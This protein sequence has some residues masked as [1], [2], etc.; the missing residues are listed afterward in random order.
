MWK[1]QPAIRERLTARRQA[2]EAPQWLA[3]L[4]DEQPIARAGADQTQSLQAADDVAQ[5][6][7]LLDQQFLAV[8][9]RSF[10]LANQM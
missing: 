9:L 6:R 7:A 10:F 8:D 2:F 4:L 3:R 5:L 1:V